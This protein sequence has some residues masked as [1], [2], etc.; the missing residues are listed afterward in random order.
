MYPRL[1]PR[2]SILP[3]MADKVTAPKIRAMKG[4][5]IRI[6]CLTAYD[7]AFGAMSDSAGVDLILVGDSVGNA[8]LGY[9]DTVPVTLAEMLHHTRATARGVSRALL[10]ADLPFGSYQSSVERAVDSAVRLVKAG[11]EA[12]KLEGTYTEAISAIVRAGIPVVGH[13]GMTPQSTHLFGGPRVQ[14]KGESG[15]AVVE[16]ARQVESAGA[17][18]VVLELIPADLAKR[19][20]EAI[21]IPTIGIGAGSGCSGQ[22][23]VLTDILGIER[24]NFK[25]AK[26][27]LDGWNLMQRAIQDYACEVRQDEFPGP[28]NS[29]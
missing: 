20:T 18:A 15:E 29:F 28:E 25:H 6:V 11:A 24:G 19:V 1:R 27:Y 8:L 10:V 2:C 12:V 17:F 22:I 23:Q 9:P 3:T 7:A 13:V 5:G 21:S 4:K 26:K 14:G 16:A